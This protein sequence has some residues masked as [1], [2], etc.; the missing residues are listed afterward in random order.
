MKDKIKNFI[1]VII[2]IAIILGTYLLLVNNFEKLIPKYDN[3]ISEYE[4]PN[5]NY[6][7]EEYWNE[8]LYSYMSNVNYKAISEDSAK[9]FNNI[10]QNLINY[11]SKSYYN[12][13]HFEQSIQNLYI[14]KLQDTKYGDINFLVKRFSYY[15]DIMYRIVFS[16]DMKKIDYE[17]YTLSS[18][19]G[20]YTD[21]SGYEQQKIVSIEK[22]EE[23]ITIKDNIDNK[24]VV[25]NNSARILKQLGII[26]NFE[27]DYMKFCGLYILEDSD[28]NIIVYYDLDS[29]LIVKILVGF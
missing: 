2:I 10:L 27:P 26:D 23:T 16:D 14:G 18:K 17:C 3:K 29:D 7:G 1:F 8:I 4:N 28:N 25:I 13:E 20:G 24:E 11:A 21:Y 9:S 22:N 19:Y 15:S 12:T 5:K 6:R